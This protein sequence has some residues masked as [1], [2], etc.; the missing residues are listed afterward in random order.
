MKHSAYRMRNLSL[1]LLKLVFAQ[2]ISAN[3]WVVSK[4]AFLFLF[5]FFF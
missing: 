1:K 2:K 3:T 4:V 5:F